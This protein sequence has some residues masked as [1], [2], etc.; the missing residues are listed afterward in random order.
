MTT[1]YIFKP[2]KHKTYIAFRN[3]HKVL[4]PFG[5]IA[6]NCLSKNGF[7]YTFISLNKNKM[8]KIFLS[9]GYSHFNES[10]NWKKKWLTPSQ[11]VL[12]FMKKLSKET[13]IK[14]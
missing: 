4:K 11:K 5:K 7:R 3:G 12:L 8:F 10:K 1:K 2:A 9:K 6:E 14:K 13:F